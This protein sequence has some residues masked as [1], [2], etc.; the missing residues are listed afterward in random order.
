MKI[1]T[2]YR[3]GLCLFHRQSRLLGYTLI[4]IKYQGAFQSDTICLME[5][6]LVS[7]DTKVIIF[8]MTF[9]YE[10]ICCIV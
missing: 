6:P 10:F 7:D 1:N 2:F 8:Y 4:G 5:S 9:K 3:D